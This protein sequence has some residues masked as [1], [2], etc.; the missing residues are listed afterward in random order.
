MKEQ[1]NPLQLYEH[2][3]EAYKKIKSAFESGQKTIGVV[4]AT[5]TGKTY[6]AL[7]FAYEHQDKKIIWLV[8]S[9]SI[10]EHIQKIIKD[11]NLEKEF[12]NIEFRTYQSLVNCSRKDLKEL[13]LDI[14]IIDEFQYLGTPVWGTRTSQIVKTHKD[15]ITYGMTAYTVRDRG[16]FFERDMANPLSDEIFSNQIVSRYDLVDA[17]IDLVLPKPNYKSFKAE[18][19]SDFNTEELNKLVQKIKE[20]N[21]TEKEKKEFEK[22]LDTAKKRIT[23]APRIGDYI[24]KYVLPNGKYIYFCPPISQD[25]VNDIETIKQE[26]LEW[27]KKVAPEQDIVIYTSTSEMKDLGRKNREAFYNDKDLD[28]N[29]VSNKLRVMFAINQYNLG[30][31]APNINGVILGRK[32]CSDIVYFEQIGRALAV[33]GDSLEN[34]KEYESKTYE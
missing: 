9:V 24:Q 33:R 27:F 11:L 19:F 2:N 26:A 8:P 31:H 29:D 7:Q 16:T 25:G 32:T 3:L 12:S 17:M 1:N 15:L 4:H 20:S 28:G 5:G 22:L 30:V 14:L 23:E 10:L 13:D 6:L 18:I 34:I 21:Y